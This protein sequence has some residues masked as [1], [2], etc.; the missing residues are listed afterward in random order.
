MRQ[1]GSQFTFWR[2]RT[3]KFHRVALLIETSNAYARGLLEGIAQNLHE[4]GMWSVF[5]PER[6]RGEPAPVWLRGWHGDGIIARVES[7]SIARAVLASGLPAV[8]VSAAGLLPG[9][10]WVHSD[11]RG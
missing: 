10:P 6:G 7:R 11:V 5:L 3:M 8:D 9:A 2:S 4:Q 1:R